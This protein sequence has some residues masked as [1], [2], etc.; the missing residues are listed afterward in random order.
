M[1]SKLHNGTNLF[2]STRKTGRPRKTSPRDDR[3]IKR[4]SKAAGISRQISANLGKEVSVI[5]CLDV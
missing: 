3:M 5:E 1:I 2:D 4:L